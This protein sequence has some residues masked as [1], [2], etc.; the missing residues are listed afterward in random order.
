MAP[1]MRIFVAVMVLGGCVA[2]PNV[3][4]TLAPP[5]SVR[6]STDPGK[7][8]NK[9]INGF[10]LARRVECA[11]PC[12]SNISLARA[13]LDKASPAH[14]HVVEESLYAEGNGV[15]RSGSYTVAVFELTDGS[16]VAVG[17]SCAGVNPCQAEP[18]YLAVE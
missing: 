2:G 6:P 18:T 4:A 7:Y 16:V 12:A 5:G 3:A 1:A 13:A 9:T 11:D 10:P 15:V 17:I 8:A 14:A